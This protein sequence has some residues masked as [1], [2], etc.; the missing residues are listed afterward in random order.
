MTDVNGFALYFSRSP[1]PWRRDAVVEEKDV[2]E[3]PESYVHVGMYAYRASFLS[4]YTSL[5]ETLYERE[6]KL[7]Q[8]RAIGHGFKIHVAEADA[9]PSHG[10]DSEKDV[11][12][13]E[14][15]VLELLGQH[16]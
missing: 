2:T 13:A 3:F 7:E 8:L 1:I 14:R 6:E 5:S 15:A 11:A 9:P 10:V 4:A 12:E 16:G